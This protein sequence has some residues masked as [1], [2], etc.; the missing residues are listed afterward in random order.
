M[1]RGDEPCTEDIFPVELG[2]EESQSTSLLNH[3]FIKKQLLQRQQDAR[4]WALIS[5]RQKPKL[6]LLV[7]NTARSTHGGTAAQALD[8]R[9]RSLHAPCHGAPHT[10]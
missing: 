6:I 3:P 10:C 8:L 5:R 1:Y 4:L 2:P 9:P 7:A